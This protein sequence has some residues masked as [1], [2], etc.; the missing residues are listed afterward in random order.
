MAMPNRREIAFLRESAARLREMAAFD[1]P[2]SYRLFAMAAELDAHADELE[3]AAGLT[4]APRPK[5]A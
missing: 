3:R 4:P 5:P 2:I 1:T